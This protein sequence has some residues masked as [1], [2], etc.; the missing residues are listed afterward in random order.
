MASIDLVELCSEAKVE[1]CRATRDLRSCGRYVQYVLTSCGHASLCS[2]CSQRYDICP[3]C[4]VPISKTGNRLRPRL[5]Y[6]CIEAGLISKRCDERFQEREDGENQ[7]T[8]DVQRLYAFDPVIAFLLDEAVVKE[9]CKRTLS[10]IVVE[11]QRICILK[12]IFTSF[13]YVSLVIYKNNH[14]SLGAEAMET[15]IDLLLKL[16]L[17]LARI[18][19][20][21]EVLDSSCKGSLSS[22]TH[23]LELLQESVLKA[24]QCLRNRTKSSLAP[25]LYCSVLV[26]DFKH[27][28]IMI[29]CERHQFLENVGSRYSDLSSWRSV[30]R[31]RKAAAIRRSWPDVLNQTADS[32]VQAGS[33]FIEDALENLDIEQGQMQEMREGSELLSLQKNG[34]LFFMSKIEGL[35]GCYPFESLRAGVDVLFLRGS[36]DLVVA[37]QA[38]FLYYLFDRHWTMPDETWRHIIDDFAATFSITR[39][40]LLESLIFYLLDD[41]TA[42]ALQEARGLLPEISG[43]ST[44][45]KIAQVLLERENPETALMVL[46]WSGRDGSQMV[47]LSEA[48][49]AVRV[50]VECGLLTEAFMHQRMLCTKVRESKFKVGP[51]AGTSNDLAGQFRPWEDWVEILVTELCCL[52]IKRN[53]VDRMIELPWNL[54]EEK[55][56]H[57]CLLDFSIHDPSTT[58]GSLLVVFYLQRH[59]YA[60]AYQVDTKLK[61]VEQDFI[62][63]NPISEEVSSK[64]RS[65]SEW[66]ATLVA[67]AIELLPPVQQEQVKSGKMP[68]DSC[69]KVDVPEKSVLPTVQEPKQASLLVPMPSDSSFVP[70]TNNV[71]TFKPSV[72]EASAKVGGS[73]NTSK[74]APG[75]VFSSSVL[76]ERLFTNSGR[77]SKTPVSIRKN[78]LN[79]M[80]STP[81]ADR[82]SP[83]KATPL[84]EAARSSLEVL[85]NSFLNLSQFEKISPEK[86]RKLFTR[87]S[88]N[89]S[90]PFPSRP[91]TDAVK[92]GVSDTGIPDDRDGVT[93][94]V[95]SRDDPIDVAW[96]NHP[97]FSDFS[98]VGRGV[99]LLM[100]GMPMVHPDGLMKLTMGKMRTIDKLLM[101]LLRGKLAG[102]P[103]SGQACMEYGFFYLVNHGVDQEF[104]TSVLQASRQFFSLPL[105]QKMKLSRKHQR[106]HCIPRI[107]IRL[108]PPTK[109]SRDKF[110][111]PRVWEDVQ[112]ISGSTLHRVR[113][114]GQERCSLAFFADPNPDCVV[115]CVETC[116]TAAKLPIIDLSSPDRNSTANSIRQAC[117][118]YGFFYLVN[119]GVEEELLGRVF[120]GSRKFFALPLDEKMKFL[121]KDHRGYTPLYAENL[122]PSS[123]SKG[124]L[125]YP[126]EEIYGA[127]AHSDYG[128]ITLLVSDGVPG[129]QIC[130]EKGKEPRVWE[131]VLHINGA[132]IVNIG[133]IMERWTNCLFRK[134][135]L[136]EISTNPWRRL[137]TRASP[138]HACME[139]GFFY[140]VNHGVD[141]EFVTS[142]LQASRQFFSLPLH[143]KMKLSMK[144][145]RGYNPLYSENFDPASIKKGKDKFKQPQVWEDVHHIDGAF[146]VNMGDMM[147]RWTNG[148]FGSTLHRVMPSGKERYSM[149]FFSDP[150]PDCIV[151]CIETCCSET[152]P[153]RFPPI[154]SG[155]YLEERLAN[156]YASS[157]SSTCT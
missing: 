104:V 89:T 51:L 29:W 98:I 30:V 123:S 97:S 71:S 155:E 32:S 46:R 130:R 85:P 127:S 66:R 115:K 52:C 31:E 57:K 55:Y 62:S 77:G 34:G 18:S 37:K 121:R 96:S 23:D 94:T 17:H 136:A 47:S 74:F 54:D 11:L 107:L 2:E 140:L 76:H 154:C 87:Q 125:G 36:A 90:S 132:F 6:E 40:S 39:H 119:H 120:E 56:L 122:D 111:E 8:A 149:A 21:V 75:N 101:L 19:N 129:L 124:E 42:E 144:D 12:L 68:P 99:L 103:V 45:P 15:R 35:A 145:T 106:G 117:V 24:K 16:S 110:K 60:E 61:S 102:F 5:Y 70:Q 81:G 64:M 26:L 48:V 126:D 131:D 157:S 43:P 148:L 49:T 112:H 142:V 33:L 1:R 92:V 95:T 135:D 134:I 7:L 84:K 10:N 9:W 86:G 147:E 82:A 88:R 3:I 14:D 156:L 67:T 78:H 20:V 38:I 137:P 93:W 108:S 141:Q 59:R 116:C 138:G 28:E 72:L 80:F 58:T 50:R 153:P 25:I 65:A 100:E 69:E 83:L 27:A 128:M 151:K 113:P 41:Y 118:E 114:S 63:D 22:R 4:R 105:H 44:H 133:D 91:T 152:C 13:A 146:I 150:N 53:L 73:A 109:V 79:D 143:Q 139:Y